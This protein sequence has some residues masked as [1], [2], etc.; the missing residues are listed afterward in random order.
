MLIKDKTK[1]KNIVYYLVSM[2]DK[3]TAV[4]ARSRIIKLIIDYIDQ[5]KTLARE[6]FR[7]LV[8]GF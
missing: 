2:L 4:S 8:K 5:F 3:I 6:V 1:T 7:K